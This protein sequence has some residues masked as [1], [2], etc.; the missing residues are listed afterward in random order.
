MQEI[1]TNEKICFYKKNPQ[2]LLNHYETLSKC[3]PH[4]YLILTKFLNDWVKIV[5]FLIKAYFCLSPD[6]PGTHCRL[7]QQLWII[8][9]MQEKWGLGEYCN[10][11]CLISSRLL[12]YAP[13]GWELQDFFLLSPPL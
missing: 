11:F 8:V 9:M 10:D 13:L 4:E 12:T 1:N 3:G 7:Y 6:S 5:D 2:F